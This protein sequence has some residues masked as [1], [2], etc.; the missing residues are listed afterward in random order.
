V[1]SHRDV[2]DAHEEVRQELT[3]EKAAALARNCR[4]LEDLVAGLEELQRR[5]RPGDRACEAEREA[6]RAL[7]DEARRFRWYLEVQREAV[8]IR[9]R[10]RVD[11]FYPIPATLD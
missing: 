9:G 2:Q 4:R 1:R 5:R 6:F 11:E 7:R 8:G 3:R 10:A